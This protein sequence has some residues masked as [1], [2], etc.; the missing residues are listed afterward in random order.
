MRFCYS[1]LLKLLCTSKFELYASLRSATPRTAAASPAKPRGMRR[2]G[3]GAAAA[4]ALL[5]KPRASRALGVRDGL[6]DRCPETAS[7]IS[8]QDD[9]ARGGR[10]FRPP[11]AYDDND[12]TGAR[13]K[14]LIALQRS[15]AND[16]VVDGRYIR[17]GDLSG[18]SVNFKSRR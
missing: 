11:W 1:M 13:D 6:L 7:C 17:C 8:S 15:E 10:S 2:R 3:V 4:A 14:L 5:A 9:A 18:A 16:A 12:W